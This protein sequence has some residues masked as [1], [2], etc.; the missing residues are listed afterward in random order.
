ME[1]GPQFRSR[2]GQKSRRGK[3][4]FCNSRL[5]AIPRRFSF[6]PP[7]RPM[8]S[9]VHSPFFEA[10]TTKVPRFEPLDPSVLSSNERHREAGP[11]M[12]DEQHRDLF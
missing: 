8:E 3:N 12:R 11:I 9:F 6:V 10:F 1:I 4:E 7:P 2:I 5:V